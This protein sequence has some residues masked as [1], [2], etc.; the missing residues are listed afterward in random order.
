MPILT[1]AF[2]VVLDRIGEWFWATLQPRPSDTSKYLR[3][4]YDKTFSTELGSFV[5]FFETNISFRSYYDD[6]LTDPHAVFRL[7]ETPMG[8]PAYSTRILPITRC[9]VLP[10]LPP[11]ILQSIA[12]AAVEHK[13]RGWRSI[14][15][16]LGLV[17]K[18]W[19]CML[20]TFFT[21]FTRNTCNRHQPSLLAVARSLEMRPE[22][23]LLMNCFRL[24]DYAGLS[25]GIDNEK[26]F[27]ARCRAVLTILSCATAIKTIHLPGIHA[28]L[29]REFVKIL[30][31]LENVERCTIYDHDSHMG[32]IV[33]FNIGEIQQFI[34]RWN[35]LR[36][37]DIAFRTTVSNRFDPIF[38]SSQIAKDS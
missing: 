7:R 31:R 36:Q 34:A 32:K 25:R 4:A 9:Q 20:D 23:G 18:A 3:I 30:L 10:A 17:C 21:V 28:S 13:F 38:L 12:K 2:E 14:V 15:L 26:Q 29:R 1:I 22:R 27:I 33:E 11:S 37:L 8:I 16:S 6:V 5:N 24:E 35:R 19:S